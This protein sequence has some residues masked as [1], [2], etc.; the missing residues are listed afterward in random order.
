MMQ[1]RKSQQVGGDDGDDRRRPREP[2]DR[3][4]RFGVTNSARERL[5]T[6]RSIVLWLFTLE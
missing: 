5:E 6:D 4:T 2:S 3:E 1:A